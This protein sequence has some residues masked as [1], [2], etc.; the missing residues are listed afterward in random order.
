MSF[1]RARS[2]EQREIRRRTIL[3]TAAA[4]LGEMPVAE[5]SLNELSRRVGLA[6]S[7]LSRYFETR[8]AVLLELLD[9]F[10]HD[11]AQALPHELSSCIDARAPVEQRAGQ[12]AE[13]LSRSLAERRALCELFGAQAAVLEKNVTLEVARRHKRNSLESL[14]V[15]AEL[16]LDHL[17]ELGDRSQEFCLHAMILAGA[18]T[19]Y[20]PPPAVILAVYE[21]D[22]DLAVLQ[23]E[24]GPA[25]RRGLESALLGGL[26]RSPLSR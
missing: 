4:M 10:L 17:P 12:L 1:Q 7:A 6:K 25:L 9:H 3:D 23:S 11:W 22:P 13:V 18:L 8:E 20:C 15:M 14:A 24:L 2:D 5:V 26:P 16:V 19:A 21:A